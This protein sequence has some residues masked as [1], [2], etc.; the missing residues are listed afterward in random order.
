[1]RIPAR[2]RLATAPAILL[3]CA[4][5][6]M[7]LVQQA[8]P[9]GNGC[10]P[11]TNA[12]QGADISN[13]LIVTARAGGTKQKKV[14][15]SYALS[16]IDRAEL[17][18]EAPFGVADALKSVPGFWVESSGGEAGSNIR[19]RGIPTDGYSSINFNSRLPVSL[20]ADDEGNP[21]A[22]TI[23]NIEVG[24]AVYIARSISAGAFVVPSNA[25]LGSHS[26]IAR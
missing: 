15:A 23:D 16:T 7:A 21:R 8:A 18:L 17:Q 24:Q 12:A 5:P 25:A 10:D 3:G 11:A 6:I 2:G 19:V 13:E 26:N 9:G 1:M 22:G 4:V 14:E 20:N